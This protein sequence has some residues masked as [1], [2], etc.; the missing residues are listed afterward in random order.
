M[1]H[2]PASYEQLWSRYQNGQMDL[3]EMVRHLAD[4]RAFAIWVRERA[5]RPRTMARIPTPGPYPIFIELADAWDASASSAETPGHA[6]QL[7]M[8]A[9]ALRMI[10]STRTTALT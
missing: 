1:T 10:V 2:P 9:D 4:D 3:G 5:Q 6:E 7:R 8:C